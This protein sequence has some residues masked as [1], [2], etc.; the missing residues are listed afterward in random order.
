MYVPIFTIKDIAPIPPK[1]PVVTLIIFV[2]FVFKNACARPSIIVGKVIAMLNR[3][4]KWR[5]SKLNNGKER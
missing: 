4:L 3:L 1:I 5:K 2:L